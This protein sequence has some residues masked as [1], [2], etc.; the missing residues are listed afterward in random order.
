LSVQRET[1]G[2]LAETLANL[3]DVVRRRR[4]MAAKVRAMASE[5][6]A[7]MMILGGLPIA[8]ILLLMVTSPTYLVPLFHD[9]RGYLLDGLALAMLGTG[10]GV[11]Q[12]LANFEI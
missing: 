1:G 10:I 7:T 9:V 8:V 5:T 11:M 12:K 6:R 4:Q 2:N 3:G